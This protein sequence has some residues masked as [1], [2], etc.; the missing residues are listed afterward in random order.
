ME[1]IHDMFARS[2]LI[3]L[4]A[5]EA[6]KRIGIP[7]NKASSFGKKALTD[8]KIL[9]RIDE[10]QKETIRRLDVS[11]DYVIRNIVETIER[12]KQ[13]QPVVNRKGEPVLIE[14]ETGQ[15]VPAYTFDAKGVLRGCELLGKHLGLFTEKV[16][17]SVSDDTADRLMRARKRISDAS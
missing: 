9:E 3:D 5:T 17:L 12:C 13:T 2:Y 1:T 7:S 6:A 8:P 14:N 10:L 15:I 4:N 11:V 16:E